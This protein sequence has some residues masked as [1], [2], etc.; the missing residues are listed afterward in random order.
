MAGRRR[1]H[2]STRVRL[3]DKEHRLLSDYARTAGMAN[4]R[5]L[6]ET[7]LAQRATTSAEKAH[8]ETLVFQRDWAINEVARVGNNINQIAKQ[9]NSQRGSISLHGIEQALAAVATAL[10]DLRKLWAQEDS[11]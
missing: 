7:T 8:A 10:N 4:S 1:Y 5:Y 2:K 11:R 6:V 3:T 9:L